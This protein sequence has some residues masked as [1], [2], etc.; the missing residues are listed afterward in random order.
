MS[1]AGEKASRKRCSGCR[2]WKPLT[3]FNRRS[4]AKDGRQWVCREC[5]RKYHRDNWDRHMAQI[6]ARRKRL[7]RDNRKKLWDYFATHSCADCGTSDPRVLEFD[8]L[9]DKRGAISKMALDFAWNV[10]E[11][12]IAK[13]DVVCA[14][15]HRI[16]TYSRQA[17]WRS[18][19]TQAVVPTR[20]D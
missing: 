18:G 17:T 15:C 3:D 13:C 9:R 6:R 10:I 19:P 8:H 11:A 16:R 1:V 14:N 4:T 2:Q 12:E 5:S 7:R 20:A